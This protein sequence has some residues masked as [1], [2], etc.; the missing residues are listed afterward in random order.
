[1]LD[2]SVFGRKKPKKAARSNVAVLGDVAKISVM[3]YVAIVAGPPI[4]AS[5]ANVFITA[6]VTGGVA[7]ACYASAGVINTGIK[8]MITAYAINQGATPDNRN[9]GAY[10]DNRQAQS[11]DYQGHPSEHRRRRGSSGRVEVEEL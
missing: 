10:Q 9:P 11:F 7:Y 8:G 1:M 2:F 5:A 6:S 4:A 3:G